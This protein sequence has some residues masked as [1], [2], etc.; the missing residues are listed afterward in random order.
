MGGQAIR[1]VVEEGSVR[2]AGSGRGGR[3]CGLPLASCHKGCISID[4]R[5]V[6]LHNT[7]ATIVK[8][9]MKLL[10]FEKSAFP[11]VIHVP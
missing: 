11:L 2:G 7:S 1:E 5:G 6:Q 10:F 9:K 8:L 4:R 3:Q